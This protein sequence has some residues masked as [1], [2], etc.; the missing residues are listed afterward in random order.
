MSFAK[1]DTGREDRDISM[2]F[3]RIFIT[4]DE[5]HTRSQN[6][7]SPDGIRTSDN[8]QEA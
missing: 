4:A 2:C 6:I 3:I 7:R 8:E 1:M 5:K